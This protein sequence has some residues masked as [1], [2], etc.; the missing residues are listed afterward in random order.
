MSR[1]LWGCRVLGARVGGLHKGLDG[2]GVSG[3]RAS[4]FMVQGVRF[5][6]SRCG[7]LEPW[8]F[9]QAFVRLGLGSLKLRNRGVGVGTFPSLGSVAFL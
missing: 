2:F 7:G 4:G 8:E 9:F 5:R 1:D 6:V 3:C